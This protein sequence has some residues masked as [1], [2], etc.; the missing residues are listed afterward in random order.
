MSK[1]INNPNVRSNSLS[2]EFQYP[3]VFVLSVF[4]IILVVTILF[5]QTP[6][7]NKDV[8]RW[9]LLFA[10]TVNDNFL[11]EVW[12]G[13]DLPEAP[14][15]G[16]R[17]YAFLLGSTVCFTAY[18]LGS[19]LLSFFFKSI[20]LRHLEKIFF[21]CG[22]GMIVLSS[23]YLYLGLLGRANAPTLPLQLGV[24]AI[25]FV[26]K[27]TQ[28][29]LRARTKKTPK[30]IEITRR[31]KSST[32]AKFQIRNGRFKFDSFIL[33]IQILA[34]IL[35]SSFYIFSS[36]QPIFEYDATEYHVQG[37]RE[38]FESGTVSFFPHNVYTNMP[39][40]MEMFYTIGFNLT[41]DLGFE[42]QDVLRIGSLI[43]KTCA[44]NF[45]FL[46]ALGLYTLS[47]RLFKELSSRL[48][49]PVLYL[50][51]P[52]VFEV[53]ISGIN[54]CALGFA[55]FSTFYVFIL[56]LH[57]KGFRQS[58]ARNSILLG[59]FTGFAMSVK[60]TGVVFVFIP[61]LI[62]YSF[63][64]FRSFRNQN[65]SLISKTDLE[66]PNG[67]A[68]S[69][70]SKRRIFAVCIFLW[71]LTSF[72]IS[73][74]WYIRNLRNTGNP[75]YPLA[76]S[77]FGD[78]TKQW[79]DEI[80]QR[81]KRAH[82]ASS[83]RC[84]D[85]H[86]AITNS[87]YRDNVASPFFPLVAIFGIISL[88][89]S[90]FCLP[91]YSRRTDVATTNATRTIRNVSLLRG[92]FLI[93]V[94]FWLLWFFA[95]HR[96]VRFLLPIAPL[97]CFLLGRF[98][99][100]LLS[101]KSLIIKYASFCL[102]VVSLF[103]SGLMIDMLGQGRMAPLRSLERDLVAFGD[104]S[105]YFNDR[106]ELFFDKEGRA[107]RKLLLVGEAKAFI[108]RVPVVYST[109][110]NNSPLMSCLEGYIERN[111]DG[112]VV[113]ITNPS[114]IRDNLLREKI[115]FILVNYSELARFRSEGNYGFNN[116]EINENLFA[117]LLNANIIVKYPIPSEH[118]DVDVQVYRVLP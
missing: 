29:F 96:I 74:G 84:G 90:R 98:L 61:A 115:E 93:I 45:I 63:I 38:I 49:A 27:I 71:V 79:N 55:L 5:F 107:M 97:S 19:L 36:V 20:R 42:Y 17:I 86:Q 18:C 113:R 100:L 110:W 60:Y 59:F 118:S 32:K 58:L 4:F 80:N 66:K 117:K 105:I 2:K 53:G 10:P 89:P 82:S 41:R 31:L 37:A 73:G 67:Y 46:T 57:K 21:S 77:Y 75:V 14:F 35:L 54:D 94:I 26:V 34:L 22:V 99:Y 76:Y 92:T 15:T 102:V 7:F 81:W 87:L 33:F 23:A 68:S 39:L 111:D 1:L 95:T 65:F 112:K 91:L 88:T 40:G 106:P 103:Y 56:L 85:F 25:F 52:G 11:K 69:E 44:T 48:W 9:V 70:K 43:G 3:F 62:A 114:K 8:C 47:T 51:F 16:E 12:F 101:T 50:S 108:Y 109:C 64:L 83:F 72:I 13:V 28:L 104:E 24:V 78:S 116:P 6:I 30:H